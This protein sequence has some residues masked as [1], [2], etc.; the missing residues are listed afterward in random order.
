M[1]VSD[2]GIREL[3]HAIAFG[4]LPGAPSSRRRPVAAQASHV[5]REHARW[6]ETRNVV[7]LCYSPKVRHGRV[8]DL[9]LQVL[10]RAKRPKGRVPAHERIPDAISLGA[11]GRRGRIPTDVREVGAMRLE[12]LVSD[13]RP[14]LPGYNIGH[15]FGGSGTLGC[16]VR[17]LETGE[18]L[19][20]SCGH[21]IARNGRAAPDDRVLVPSL[22]EAEAQDMLETAFFGSLVSFSPLSFEFDKAF[23][24][25][26]AAT[27]RP[28]TPEALDNQIAL[29]GVR[30]S[31]VRADAPMGLPVR[32]VGFASETTYG[33]LLAR[34]AILGL[35]YMDERGRTRT[36][37]FT[38]LL[39][40]TSFTRP[41]DS[42]ALVMDLQ[43][44]AVGLHMG[45]GEGI[46]VC[47][48]I[49]RVLDRVRCTL[50][51]GAPPVS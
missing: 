41:G 17:A 14:V 4:C 8:E 23:T 22:E 12:T 2:G 10:V 30:P 33:T 36:A 19:G 11:L 21:V 16:A 37:W 45:S 49:Q 28:D 27:V 29:L 32:K 31:G 47:A 39:G 34:H 43:G 18:R 3:V 38:D 5:A 13:M 26:D 9:S 25:V 24:N 6:W 40:V 46:S 20:L 1:P 42:G 50:D 35:P 51:V 48:P 15:R 7:G 44:E